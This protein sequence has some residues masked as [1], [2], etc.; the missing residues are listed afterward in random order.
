MRKRGTL[1]QG[2]PSKGLRL[3][4]VGL[5]DLPVQRVPSKAPLKQRVLSKPALALALLGFLAAAPSAAAAEL[6]VRIA[7]RHGQPVGDAVVTLVQRDAPA[8][9]K[10]PLRDAPVRRVIDQKA[11]AFTPYVEVFRPGDEVAYR[12]SDRTRHHVYSFSPI[13][14]FE[15]VLVPG[16][17]SKPLKLERS[18]VIAVGCNIHDGMINY[19]YISEAPWVARTDASGAV[20]FRGLPAGAYDVRVWQPRLPPKRPDL[21]QSGLSLRADER[22]SVDFALSLLPDSRLQF[23]REHT[24]Y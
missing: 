15:F 1:S 6:E 4:R 22:R 23:D 14:A 9:R 20:A 18:G 21:V 2:L 8:A 12:N 11:L 10:E 3:M 7:D 13:K 19:L 16:E 5:S 17:T 24:R